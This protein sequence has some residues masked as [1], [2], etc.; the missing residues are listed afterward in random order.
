ML[1]RIVGEWSRNLI[2]SEVYWHL[3]KALR[4]QKISNKAKLIS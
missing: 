4:Q 2:I 1:F 3:L